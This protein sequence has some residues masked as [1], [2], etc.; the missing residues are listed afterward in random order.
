METH[1]L[2]KYLSIWITKSSMTC[3]RYKFWRRHAEKT[4]FRYP[5]T[6]IHNLNFWYSLLTF[7]FHFSDWRTIRTIAFEVHPRHAIFMHQSSL[8]FSRRSK[9]LFLSP[10]LSVDHH[11]YS[12]SHPIYY[13]LFYIFQTIS[14]KQYGQIYDFLVLKLQFNFLY[15][16]FSA[17]KW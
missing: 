16:I 5:S 6:S 1:L 17:L 2:F 9:L 11:H 3:S 4:N 7:S 8:Q 12:Q 10:S 14:G 13:N 15:F